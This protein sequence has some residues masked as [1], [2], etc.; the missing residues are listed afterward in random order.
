[1]IKDRQEQTP[2]VSPFGAILIALVITGAIF[3][4]FWDSSLPPLPDPVTLF[5]A[6][7]SG[8]V[9]AVVLVT[10]DVRTNLGGYLAHTRILLPIMILGVVL[11]FALFPGGL[12]VSVEIG[13]VTLLWAD[14][15][16]RL[17]YRYV[18]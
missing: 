9:L 8:I 3:V 1:M 6:L 5:A 18:G 7:G 16:V 13:L 4:D 17:A 2:S 15:I 12:P 11:G 14:P 10:L